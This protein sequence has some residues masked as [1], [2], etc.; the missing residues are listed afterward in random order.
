MIPK[1]VIAAIASLI[2]VTTG[3]VS[4]SDYDTKVGELTIRAE[5]AQK[6]A[7]AKIKA[8]EEEVAVAKKAAD[9]AKQFEA[10]AIIAKAEADKAKAEA[11]A[12]KKEAEVAKAE[13]LAQKKEAEAK[14]KSLEGEVAV[15]K[16]KEAKAKAEAEETLARERL[17]QVREKEKVEAKLKALEAKPA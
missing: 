7:E 8:L 6:E 10:R 3:C 2:F 9:I 15:A 4:K 1:F 13:A 5:K 16:D 12:Q 11:L 17:L 14:I